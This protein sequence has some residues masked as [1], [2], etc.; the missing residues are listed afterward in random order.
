[1][2]T[3]FHCHW[4]VVQVIIEVQ[5]NPYERTVLL[6]RG[7]GYI[8]DI[9]AEGLAGDDGDEIRLPDTAL[10]FPSVSTLVLRNCSDKHYRQVLCS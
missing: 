1:M 6:L 5:G 3:R 7:E 10:G 8:E 9:V 4:H 2:L